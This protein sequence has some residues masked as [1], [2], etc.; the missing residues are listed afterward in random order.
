MTSVEKVGD[1]PARPETWRVWAWKI[2][3]PGLR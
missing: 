1:L 3:T 2:C